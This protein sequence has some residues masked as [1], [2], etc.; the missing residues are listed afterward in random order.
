MDYNNYSNN[1]D[2]NN[3]NNSDNN[4]KNNDNNNIIRNKKNA[5]T[6]QGYQKIL[7]Q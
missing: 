4:D 5:L 6:H 2:N 3:D 7:P 1:N